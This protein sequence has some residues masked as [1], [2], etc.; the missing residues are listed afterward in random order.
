MKPVRFYEVA[1]SKDEV[2]WGGAS[3]R[4]GGVVQ[5]RTRPQDLCISMG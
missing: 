2:E 3:E 1:N 5:K 4:G